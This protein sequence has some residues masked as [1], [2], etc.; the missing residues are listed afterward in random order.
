M[1][2]VPIT[3]QAYFS[4]TINLDGQNGQNM[5]PFTVDGIAFLSVNALAA[6]LGLNLRFDEE[7]N[8]IYLTTPQPANT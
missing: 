3:Q 4:T 1:E 8:T 2:L 6:A 7:T 5:R